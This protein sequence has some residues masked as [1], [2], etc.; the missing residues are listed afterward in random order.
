MSG[1]GDKS[2]AKLEMR[3]HVRLDRGSG[4]KQNGRDDCAG[5]REHRG[6][7]EHLP[8]QPRAR[9]AERQTNR[10]LGGAGAGTREL[11]IDEVRA[12]DQQRHERCKDAQRR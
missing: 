10:E 12:D 3:H 11:K 2:D 1:V 5:D 8:S 4:A 7:D 6:L 9:A